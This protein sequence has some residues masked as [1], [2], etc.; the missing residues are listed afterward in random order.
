MAFLPECLETMNIGVNQ[1]LE[2]GAS[3]SSPIVS[4]Q[5]PIRAGEF[6]GKVTK[7]KRGTCQG[8]SGSWTL[9]PRSM[10]QR[11]VALDVYG[12]RRNSEQGKITV[13]NVDSGFQI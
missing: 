5:V 9:M 13:K 8:T 3:T 7:G 10:A 11:E 6:G 4:S 1:F 12:C 2:K